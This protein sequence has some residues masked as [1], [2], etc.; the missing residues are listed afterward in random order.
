MNA[1]LE[2]VLAFPTVFLTAGLAIVSI[3]WA[4]VIFGAL[5]IDTFD[6]DVD[7]DGIAE[8]SVEGAMEGAAEGAIEGGLE[9][10]LEGAEG[11]LEGVEGALE[12]AD[13]ALEGAEA[14]L[15]GADGAVEGGAEAAGDGAAEGLHQG[16]GFIGF[17][18]TLG[19]RRAPFTVTLSLLTLAAWAFC[20]L[21]MQYVAPLLSM[22]PSAVVGGAVLFGSFVLAV[23]VTSVT[24]RP[25]G[26]LFIT[27]EGDKR[28]DFIGRTC[29]IDTGS[30]DGKFGQATV[31]EDGGWTVIQVR[32]PNDND[33]SRGDEALIVSYDD[34]LEAFRVES[35]K[36]KD[37]RADEKVR[38]E[39]G[40]KCK[41]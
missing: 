41:T 26:P 20:V 16:L 21:G 34:R 30:V 32:N 38:K 33:L 36:T 19:L 25:L 5:D 37:E 15:E 39:R 14:A 12:S 3:Y 6:F 11:A 2:Q 9:G 35:L 23:P 13:G 8:G 29:R 18:S 40:V 28:S 7:L 17:L 22:L 10:G 1:F 31:A 24:S 27:H 4:F